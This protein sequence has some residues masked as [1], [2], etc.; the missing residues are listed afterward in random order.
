M[1]KKDTETKKTVKTSRVSETRVK[2][3]KP[4]V[5]A[6]PSSLDAPPAPD[7]FRH[8][9]I[10]AETQGFDPNSDDYYSEV[11]KRIR[12]EFPHKFDK[13]DSTTSEPVQNVA[14]AKRSATKGRRKTV[15]LTPSQVAIS[16]RLGVPLEEYAKQLAA[17]E[18]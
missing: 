12:L 3:E 17:K 8:R 4:K 7:G 2:N 10:R 14:S 18:V 16:K 1:N 6:P 11:D 5:W 9:W 13:V 15:K